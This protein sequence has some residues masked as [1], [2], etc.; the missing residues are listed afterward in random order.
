MLLRLNNEDIPEELEAP[1]PGIANPS[2]DDLA[3]E[4]RA[5]AEA[6]KRQTRHISSIRKM[7]SHPSYQAV[8]AMGTPVLPLL[9]AELRDRPDHWLVA[10]HQITGED[11]A[12]P[13]S[14]F[15]EAIE[16]WLNWG[17]DKGYLS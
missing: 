9:L 12:T 3:A 7:V 11:P 10:L 8:I 15:S 17:R 6:W 5:H 16:A 2:G 4:F 1:T 14:N 13:E